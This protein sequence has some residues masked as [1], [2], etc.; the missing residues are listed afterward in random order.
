M[1]LEEIF[2]NCMITFDTFQIFTFSQD[3][4][5]HLLKQFNFDLV[6]VFS[7]CYLHPYENVL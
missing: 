1:S 4:S 2:H 6:N 7:Q 3:T 5:N